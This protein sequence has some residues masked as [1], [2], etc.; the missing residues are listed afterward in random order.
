MSAWWITAADVR[1]LAVSRLLAS[2]AMVLAACSNEVPPGPSPDAGPASDVATP[3]CAVRFDGEVSLRVRT[4][5]RRRLRMVLDPPTPGVGLRVGVVGVG[6]D[7]SLT[8]TRVV[9]GP[10]GSAVTELIAPTDSAT[11]RVRATAECGAEASVEVAVGDRGFGSIVAEAAYRGSRTPSRLEINIASGSECPAMGGDPARRTMVPLPGGMVRFGSLPA[12]LTFTVWAQA[13]GASDLVL[14]QGC[15]APQT[16]RADQDSAASVLFVDRPLRLADRYALDLSFDLAATATGLRDRWTAPVR[17]ELTAAGSTAGFI[18]REVSRAVS[19]AS[20]SADGGTSA[21]QGAFDAA[22][23]AGLGARFEAELTTR[24][25]LLENSFDQIASTTARALG[26]VHWVVTFPVASGGVAPTESVVVL[27][28][29]TPDVARDDARLS[30]PT[31]GAIGLSVGTGDI[32]TLSL[33]HTSL[34]WAR[35]ARGALGAVTVRLGA[36]TTGEY[37]AAPLCPVAATVLRDA[38]GVCDAACIQVACRRAVDALARVFD[39]EVAGQLAVRSATSFRM[40]A[41]A[42]PM[43][44]SL[45]VDRAQGVFVG[46]WTA[47][48]AATLNGSWTL[49]HIEPMPR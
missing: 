24:G 47:E 26:A 43:P 44:G 15:A 38:S 4:S 12:D 31:E 39:D 13:I 20:G 36:S 19:E 46:Q 35:V 11:F 30:L 10:D 18:V 40:A 14:A 45:V 2:L 29:G 32:A 5:E 16:V 23:R 17:R 49:Q 34:P 1:V 41:V 27:D 3:R 9:T 6:L 37:V 42:T 25:L 48:P 7:A 8:E 33:D 21:L 22:V 28:P